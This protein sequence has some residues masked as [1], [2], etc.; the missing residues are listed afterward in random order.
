MTAQLVG[1]SRVPDRDLYVAHLSGVDQWPDDLQEPKPHFVAFLAMDA[2]SVESDRLAAFADR[3]ISQGMVYLCAWGPDCGRVHD[4]FDEA[5][6]RNTTTDEAAFWTTWNDDE[7]LVD[8]LWFAL[9]STVPT[10]DDMETHP[11]A[12]VAVVVDQPEWSEQISG[13]LA[14]TD[15]FMTE[16]LAQEPER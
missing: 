1:R 12:L 15:R 14:D 16:I 6:G 5:I 9:F 3:L 11:S 10:E 8:A 4:I 13:A 7:E 2:S